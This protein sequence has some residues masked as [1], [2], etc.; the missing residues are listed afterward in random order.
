MII[1]GI[2]NGIDNYGKLKLI[3]DEEMLSMITNLYRISYNSTTLE[4]YI[5]INKHKEYYTNII[6]NNKN[7][8]ISLE[9]TFKKYNF[10]NNKGISIILKNIIK[11][12]NVNFI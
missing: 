1:S 2:I 11:L 6:N 12:N 8:P 4:C 7:N 9:V 3:I 5:L 10:D